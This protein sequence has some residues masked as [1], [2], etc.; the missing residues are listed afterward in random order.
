MTVSLI[1]L[2]G[3]SLFGGA[4]EPAKRLYTFTHWLEHSVLV[5]HH[6]EFNILVATISTVLALG[7][8]GPYLLYARRYREYLKLPKA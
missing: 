6:G 7:A 1:I 8:P 5:P 3:L 4:A 2:A